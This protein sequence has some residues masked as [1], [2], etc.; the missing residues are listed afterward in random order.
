MRRQIQKQGPLTRQWTGTQ[1]LENTD[2]DQLMQEQS[3]RRFRKNHSTQTSLDKL[4]ER[5]Y[6]NTQELRKTFKTVNHKILFDI[7]T[8]LL[9]FWHIFEMV[10]F[11]PQEQNPDGLHQRLCVRPSHC[12]NWCPTG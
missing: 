6:S 1:R 12:R 10:L 5:L 3:T 4:M 9:N 7:I 8:T 11:K 2:T